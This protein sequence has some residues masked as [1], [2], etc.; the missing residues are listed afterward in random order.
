MTNR[1][2]V[3]RGVFIAVLVVSV[4]AAGVGT[5]VAAQETR[6]ADLEVLQPSYIESDVQVRQQSGAT[7][8][9]AKGEQLRLYPQAFDDSDV[10]DTGVEPASAQFTQSRVGD[11]WTLTVSETGT[12]DVYW[13]VEREIA[14]GNETRTERARYEAS[15]RV[16]GGLDVTT[17]ERGELEEMRHDADAWREL[18]ATAQHQIS[19]SWIVT[20][21]PGRPSAT[22]WLHSSMAKQQIPHN[23]GAVFGGGIT[24][25][26]IG[27]F[28]FGGA[29]VASV[30]LGWHAKAITWLQQR[31]NVF[32]SVE[33]EEGELNKR[34]EQRER[35]RATESLQNAQF[36]DVY[37]PHIADA[38]RSL[39]DTPLEA[40]CNLYANGIL[41]SVGAAY[42]ARAM[43]QDGYVGVLPDPD[44]NPDDVLPDGGETPDEGDAAPGELTTD[45][46]LGMAR[47]RDVR[48]DVQPTE[49]VPEDAVTLD[50]TA[51][52]RD[53]LDVLPVDS[54][55]MLEYDIASADIDRDQIQIDGVDW[56]VEDIIARVQLEARHFDSAAEAATYF[57]D[58]LE[59]VRD[60][61]VT[62]S[63]GQPRTCRMV[64]ETLLRDSQLLDDQ[65]DISKQFAI[66]MI[67][68]AIEADDPVA[69]GIDTVADIDE[70]KYA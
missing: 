55:T 56:N 23:P 67:Q 52:E 38:M 14:D 43:G 3:A 47:A 68:S 69:D 1:H 46:V 51:A 35:D 32:E 20:L 34:F 57:V 27:L 18:N 45:D 59:D 4:L 2:V 48:V 10:V 12:Y 50:L 66:D 58:F 41:P 62:D 39:G 24:M 49:N 63:D 19:E 5:P 25:F 53:W 13:I 44:S 40:D 60:H 37:L 21:T 64:L 61:P 70:G 26:F 15:V 33:Q 28:T 7:V 42:K 17:I 36:S 9:E 22:E 11:G 6:D 31:L 8:H 29:L 16:T 30:F 54:A 65:F